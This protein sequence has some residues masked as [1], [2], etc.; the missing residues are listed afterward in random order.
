MQFFASETVG[1]NWAAVVHH[2]GPALQQF[3]VVLQKVLSAVEADRSAN[4]H[5]ECAKLETELSHASLLADAVAAAATVGKMS[6]VAEQTAK[7]EKALQALSE[8]VK[9][10]I[11]ATVQR[12]VEASH[13][14]QQKQ[15]TSENK[16]NRKWRDVVASDRP[17]LPRSLWVQ[18]RTVFLTPNDAELRKKHIDK[19][20]FG[21][22]LDTA[23]HD[24]SGPRA[25]ADDCA[26]ESLVRTGVG[27][28][29]V[30]LA[31]DFAG[32]LLAA[33][34]ITV[35]R[36]GVWQVEKMRDS[37]APSVVLMGVER[38]LSDE[39][40]ALGVIRGTRGLLPD[41]LKGKLGHVRAKRLFSAAKGAA[42]LVGSSTRVEAQPTRN[43]RLYCCSEVL[44]CVLKGGFVK[45]NWDLVRVRP[46][47]PPRFF[48]KKCGRMGGHPTEFHRPRDVADGTAS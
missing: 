10:D 32:P 12:S 19:H 38:S 8:K 36:F 41:A 5:T 28:F 40:V 9:T 29:K 24:L 25:Q 20:V 2:L 26:I 39:Q 47:E 43:V 13:E 11:A 46:Y 23:L 22:E 48:C 14:K 21:G 15:S 31:S 44:D 45:V 34:E 42:L 7:R 1:N 17:P 3:K 27:L 16:M 6:A 33:T 35:G 18:E 4:R 37:S 30:Q